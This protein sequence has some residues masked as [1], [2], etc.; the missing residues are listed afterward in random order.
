M[1]K[2]ISRMTSFEEALLDFAKAKSDKYGIVKFGDD[3]DYHYIIVIETKEIDHYTIELID[4]YGYPVPIAW[5]EPGR[6]KTFEECGFFEC[7]SVEPQLKSLAA[8][9]DLHLGTRHYFE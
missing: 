7:H 6:Y 2:E 1:I 3:S 8:V 9:V 5:F 4:L